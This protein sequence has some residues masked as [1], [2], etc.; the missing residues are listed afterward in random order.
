MFSSYHNL[1]FKPKNAF[2]SVSLSLSLSVCVCLSTLSHFFYFFFFLLLPLFLTLSTMCNHTHT[3]THT[4]THTHTH[5]RARAQC[6]DYSNTCEEK[7]PWGPSQCVLFKQVSSIQG[8][9][10]M[11]FFSVPVIKSISFQGQ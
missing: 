10:R 4:H 1:P 11:V 5:T 3:Y 6:I 8:T 7:T 2:V 9:S